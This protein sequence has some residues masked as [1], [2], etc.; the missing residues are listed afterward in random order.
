M[1]AQPQALIIMSS[2]RTLKLAEPPDHPEIP[3]GF[4]LN[5]LAKFIQEFGDEYEFVLATPD[6]NQPQLDINGFSLWLH[7][8]DRQAAAQATA[9]LGPT[10]DAAALRERF[11]EAHAR[12]EAE[13]A[14]AAPVLGRLDV[15]EPLPGT[16]WEARIYRAELEKALADLSPRRY[17]SLRE[18]V[19]MDR[20]PE[21]SFS[22]S[23]VAFMHMPGGHAPMAD[24]VDDPYLGEVLNRLNEERVLAS[25]ICHG[26]AALLSSRYRV[27]ADGST[28]EAA[29]RFTGAR[30][31]VLPKNVERYVLEQGYL[32]VPGR[33]TRLAFDLD[34]ALSD[35]GFDVQP[36]EFGEI[37]VVFDE[38]TRLLTG[39]GPAACGR[40]VKTLRAQLNTRA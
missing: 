1:P 9:E 25:L 11:P 17:L 10:K 30:I 36:S 37:L 24:S 7:A 5:E 35:A 32:K 39:N 34:D 31:T 29:S 21:N 13:V 26:P 22:F 6:G 28:V 3:T 2:A 15:S 19:A 23:D 14:A 27:A 33:T 18:L 8:S 38:R 4:Y 20:D 16:D 12:R 40:Q